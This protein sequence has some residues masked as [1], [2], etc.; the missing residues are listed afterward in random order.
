M[1]LREELDNDINRFI[2]KDQEQYEA[3]YEYYYY[4]MSDYKNQ[5][6]LKVLKTHKDIEENMSIRYSP[7]S[8]YFFKLS[9][10]FSG[11]RNFSNSSPE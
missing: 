3:F 9:F 4:D 1:E 2:F 7:T 8:I 10:L 6:E 5:K 11:V